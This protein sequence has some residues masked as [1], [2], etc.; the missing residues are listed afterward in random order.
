MFSEKFLSSSLHD[1]YHFFVTNLD[2]NFSKPLLFRKKLQLIF[3]ESLFK[4]KNQQSLKKLQRVEK[5]LKGFK[6]DQTLT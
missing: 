3:K 1:L 6:Q 5:P 2:Q 4:S